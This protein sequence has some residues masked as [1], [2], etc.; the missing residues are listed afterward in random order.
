M[1]PGIATRVSGAVTVASTTTI[2]PKTDV[3]YV[4]GTAAIAT[5][6]PALGPGFSQVLFI[7]PAGAFTTVT[8]GNIGLAA[9]AVAGRLMTLVYDKTLAKWYPSYAS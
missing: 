9:T 1:I 5:I 7:I 4:T 8:T 3:I 2:Y 6:V